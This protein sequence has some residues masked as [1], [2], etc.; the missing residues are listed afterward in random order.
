MIQGTRT[1]KQI[2][3]VLMLATG[4][5][6]AATGLLAQTPA[7]LNGLARNVERAEGIRAVKTLQR[8]FAQYGQFGLWNEMSGL[9]SADAVYIWGDDKANGAKAIGDLFARQYGNGK[10]GLEPG[11]VH[12]Q[13]LEQ[14]VVDLSVDGESAKGRWYGFLMTADGKGATGIQGGVFEN[15]YVKQNGVWKIQTLNFLPQYEG[16]YETGWTNWKGQDIPLTPFHFTADQAGTPVPA[17]VGLAPTTKA[18][19]DE[20]ERRAQTLND[21]NLARNL[22]AVYGYYISRRMWDD[23][24]DLFTADSIYELGGVGVFDGPKG[25]RKALERQG[26]AG[27]TDGILNDRLQFDTIASIAPSGFEAHVRGLELGIIGDTSKRQAHWEVN[28]FDNRF[29]KQNGVWMVREMRV[30]PMFRSEHSQGWGKSRLPQPGGAA[31]DRPVPGADEGPEDRLVPAFVSSNPGTGKPVAL[32]AGYKLVATAP[33]TGKVTAPTAAKQA[34]TSARMDEVQ[35]KLAVAR[36]YDA[37]ENLASTYGDSLDDYQWPTMAGI[38]GQHGAKQIPFVGYYFGAERIAHAL[39]LEWGAPQTGGRATVSLHW[40]VQP[41]IDVAQDGRSANMRT[42]LFLIGSN[43]TLG[44][45]NGAIYPMDQLV[46][47]NGVVRLWNLSLNEPMWSMTGGWKGGWASAPQPARGR[48]A[49]PVQ[50]AAGAPA[51]GTA[52]A[53]GAAPAAPAQQRYTGQALIA[54]Y[55]PDILISD[56]GKR[57]EHFVGGTGEAWRWPQILPMWFGY[58]NPIS[59]RVPEFYLNNCV[60]CDFAPDMELTKHG[61]LNPPNGPVDK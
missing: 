29:V 43:K 57:E 59:G 37:A 2:L 58:R 46:L 10:Q 49:A 9:F 36:M 54:K 19:L 44:S 53:R 3:W 34:S 48:G 47:E 16:T 40:R 20:L 12:A 50:G 45:M 42:Y 35:R 1:T 39:D 33:L 6:A 26:P 56:L 61:Y 23:A 8:S 17:A 27:L 7:D 41:V 30:F 31:A 52:A 32:P 28:I 4:L 22:Q 11:A 24:T 25:V 18:T 51:R 55:P 38:F 15:V 14:S 21:E 5:A 60:P 13:L